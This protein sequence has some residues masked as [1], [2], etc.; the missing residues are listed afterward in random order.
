MT[1]TIEDEGI[2][3]VYPP[4][5]C[6]RP[7]LAEGAEPIGPWVIVKFDNGSTLSWAAGELMDDEANGR[8]LS[9]YMGADAPGVLNIPVDHIHVVWETEAGE[10]SKVDES[11]D[12]P[13]GFP[14]R[15]GK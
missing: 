13:E 2:H 12:V 4:E 3:E 10:W 11:V 7:P 5:G 1:T 14:M 15:A 6:E 8:Y 9:L